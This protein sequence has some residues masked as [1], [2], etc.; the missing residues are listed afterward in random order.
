MSDALH[1]QRLRNAVSFER[2]RELVDVALT[3]NNGDE[4]ADALEAAAS[5]SDV[6]HAVMF[7][8]L[9]RIR[10]FPEA[11]GVEFANTRPTINSLYIPPGS[12]DLT[13]D[14]MEDP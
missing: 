7:L 9:G 6:A 11:T 8:F 1:P 10:G 12:L 14:D 3:S 4:I 13:P 5:D 2:A